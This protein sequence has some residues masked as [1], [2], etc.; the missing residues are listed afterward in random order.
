MPESPRPDSTEEL[1]RGADR[2]RPLPAELRRRLAEQ[3][4]APDA[5]GVSTVASSA[6]A[7]P[8]PSSLRARLEDA[9]PSESQ[10]EGTAPD[11]DSPLPAER[12]AGSRWGARWV[13]PALA[14]AAVVLLVAVVGVAE[15]GG[16]GPAHQPTAAP[17]I[18]ATSSAAGTSGSSTAG[19]EGGAASTA[20]GSERAATAG[21][22]VAAGTGGGGTL[23]GAA[24]GAGAAGQP[25]TGGGASGA[26]G[27]TSGSPQSPVAAP[28]SPPPPAVSSVS[29]TFGP[30]AGGTWITVTG[31]NLAGTTRVRFGTVPAGQMVVVSATV[32]RA[33]SPAH[34]LGPVDVTVTTPGGTSPATSGDRFTYLP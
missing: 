32:V 19:A 23:S 7:R 8:L 13:T 20:T 16:G 11:H 5:A 34:T 29:P 10:G 31:R 28:P 1:L 2:P 3:L 30:M 21:G 14:A 17:K 22:S 9:L 26:G 27:G 15:R 25:A 12:A 18:G 6:D 4:T 33:L 24:A